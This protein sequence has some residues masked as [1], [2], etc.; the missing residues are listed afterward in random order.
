MGSS[1]VLQM[2][3][4]HIDKPFQ[5]PQGRDIVPISRFVSRLG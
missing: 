2:R 4:L 5:A 1:S 3:I